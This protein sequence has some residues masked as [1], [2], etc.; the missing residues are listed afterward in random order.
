MESWNSQSQPT[1]T[2]LTTFSCPLT[3]LL[4]S[5]SAEVV[6]D[7]SSLVISLFDSS[8]LTKD[9]DP[10]SSTLSWLTVRIFAERLARATSSYAAR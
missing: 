4:L 6:D 8:M 1:S 5:S 2:I 3:V 7:I 10:E 9:L